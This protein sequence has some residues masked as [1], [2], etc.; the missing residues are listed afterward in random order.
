MVHLARE[1]LFDLLLEFKIHF[2]VPI[3]PKK[4]KRVPPRLGRG[5]HHEIGRVEGREEGG[6]GE[7][8]TMSSVIHN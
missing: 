3:P 7:G 6:G 8:G 4:E 1:F 5:I 2:Q